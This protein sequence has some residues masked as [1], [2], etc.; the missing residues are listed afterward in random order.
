MLE[1]LG[2]GGSFP[3]V[4]PR[5]PP[6]PPPPLDETLILAHMRT[7]SSYMILIEVHKMHG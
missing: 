7:R 5:P 6:P 2:G 3:P 4:P 1:S